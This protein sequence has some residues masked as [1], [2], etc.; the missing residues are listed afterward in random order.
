[1]SWR[2]NAQDNGK[3]Q[4]RAIKE[5]CYIVGVGFK[6]KHWSRFLALGWT[7]QN[8]RVIEVNSTDF[9]AAWSIHGH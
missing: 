6:S 9:N 2:E 5:G 8:F 1:M 3:K 4:N 7:L